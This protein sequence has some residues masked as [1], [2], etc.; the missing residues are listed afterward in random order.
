MDFANRG[1][2]ACRTGG[3]GFGRF[4]IRGPPI[5]SR[6]DVIILGGGLGGCAAALTVL[7]DG[8]RVVMTEQ[9]DWIGGCYRL[10]PIE[11]GIG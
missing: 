9:T 4:I 3:G 8:L 2:I 10:H 6:A 7:R 5:E 11:W 1:Q